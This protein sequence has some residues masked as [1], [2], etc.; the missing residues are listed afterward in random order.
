MIGVYSEDKKSLIKISGAN[1]YTELKDAPNIEQNGN[2]LIINESVSIDNNGNIKSD[3]KLNI[4]QIDA[5]IITFG[6]NNQDLQGSFDDI[7]SKLAAIDVDSNSSEFIIQDKNNNAILL[8]NKDGITTTDIVLTNGDSYTDKT[9]SAILD[10]QF[11]NIEALKE[12]VEEGTVNERIDNAINSLKGNVNNLDTLEKIE[13]KLEE[14]HELIGEDSVKNQ[15]TSAIEEVK[16]T[17]EYYDTLEKVEATFNTIQESIDFTDESFNDKFIIQDKENN[18]ILKVDKDG[19]TTTELHLNTYPDIEIGEAVQTN[20]ENINDLNGD[21]TN[22][23]SIKYQIKT[24]IDNLKGSVDQFDT[25]EKVEDKL[26][27]LN[28]QVVD[29]LPNKIDTDIANL[30]GQTENYHT[31]ATLEDRVEE[32]HGQISNIKIDRDNEFIIQD[33]S[34]NIILAVD[35]DGLKTTEIM[36]NDL[37]NGVAATLNI[38]EEGINQNVQ[39]IQSN[40][41]AI[42]LLNANDETPGSVKYQVKQVADEVHTLVAGAPDTYNTFKEIADYIDTHGGEAAA[43]S[44]A[45]EALEIATSGLDCSQEN[46]KI[47]VQDNHAQAI[48]QVDENGLLTTNV[49]LTDLSISNGDVTDAI[50][51]LNTQIGN[52]PVNIQINNAIEALN[53]GTEEY[54][55]L[56]ELEGRIAEAHTLIGTEAVEDQIDNAIINLKDGVDNRFNTLKKLQ[57]GIESLEAKTNGIDATAETDLIIKDSEDNTVLILNNSGLRVSDLYLNNLDEEV[58]DFINR[59]REDIN[60]LN[61]GASTFNSVDYKIEQARIAL[62]DGADVNYQTL[63]QIQ[64]VITD[65]KGELSQN[66]TALDEKYSGITNQLITD[67]GNLKQDILDGGAT[68]DNENSFPAVREDLSELSGKF[69]SHVATANG[70]FTRLDGHI[71]DTNIHLNGD[72]QS[73]LSAIDGV[74]GSNKNFYI[75]DKNGNYAFAVSED[76]YTRANILVDG[77]YDL[78]EF[79]EEQNNKHVFCTR[80]GYKQMGSSVKDDYKV[81]FISDK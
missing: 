60:T 13:T 79:I 35:Q 78:K 39:N 32:V 6:N 12:Q 56:A 36:L 26:Q 37:D 15:I 73:T 46:D 33:S 19:L 30:K 58:G 8:V 21:E 76:G 27:E 42:N 1:S 16:G 81:Y 24:A 4:S 38:H 49:V 43:M 5:D 64:T 3:G 7:N 51:F 20:V 70:Q 45:I 48:L 47:I 29:T 18:A 9:I 41:N 28:T 67:L 66:D 40:Q 44:Q 72:Q 53:G 11:D 74:A 10:E 61:A 57:E 14:V 65:A 68:G 22:E 54:H 52:E 31:L 25:L 80:E 34:E 77:M 71:K 62:V 69:D 2:N 59:N 50:Q 23:K 63:K 17:V 75:V 55:T